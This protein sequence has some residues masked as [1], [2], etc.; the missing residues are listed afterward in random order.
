[1]KNTQYKKG[2]QLQAL[3]LSCSPVSLCDDGINQ[4]IPAGA[5]SLPPFPC[6]VGQNQR[7]Q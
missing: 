6:P 2:L 1:M 3:R 7:S 5:P 4:C